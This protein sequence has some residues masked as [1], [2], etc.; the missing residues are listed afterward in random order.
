VTDEAVVRSGAERNSNFL[1]SQLA[2]AVLVD[3]QI[4][5]QAMAADIAVPVSKD[6]QFTFAPSASS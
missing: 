4:G 6:T 2:C 1:A 3:L 5:M